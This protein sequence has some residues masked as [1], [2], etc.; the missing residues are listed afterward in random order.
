M[1][2]ATVDQIDPHVFVA[3]SYIPGIFLN[4]F[5]LWRTSVPQQVVVAVVLVGISDITILMPGS[6]LPMARVLRHILFQEKDS[7]H[8]QK[9]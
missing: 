7:L 3:S 8:R 2:V 6:E 9:H 5:S 4:L 1:G